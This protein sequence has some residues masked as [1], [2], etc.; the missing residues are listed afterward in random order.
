MKNE[1][2]KKDGDFT[3]KELWKI[4]ER[5]EE[6]VSIYPNM[7]NGWA[8]TYARLAD[9]ADHLEAMMARR[10]TKEKKE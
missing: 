5:A 9:A 3:R 6:Q 10:E 8:R 2:L 7:K 1:N 4:M